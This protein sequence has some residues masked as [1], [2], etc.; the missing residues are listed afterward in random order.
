MKTPE[1]G[2]NFE[3]VYLQANSYWQRLKPFFPRADKLSMPQF[4]FFNDSGGQPPFLV[5][6]FGKKSLQPEILPEELTS[7]GLHS[8]AI[9]INHLHIIG[10]NLQEISRHQELDLALDLSEE[11]THAATCIDGG[12]IWMLPRGMETFD[13]FMP[14]FGLALSQI[15]ERLRLPFAVMDV[16]EF[17]PPLGQ[18]ALLGETYPEHWVWQ[19]AIIDMAALD[20]SSK[21]EVAPLLE[22]I[23]FHLPRLAGELLVKQ[24]NRD[25]QAIL[26]DNPSLLKLK[27]RELFDEYCIPLLINGRLK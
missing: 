21:P 22:K 1:V 20:F 8:A 15:I 25:V 6:N 19:T 5:D 12:E 10:I 16:N 13:G 9:Y 11:I 18:C 3:D 23:I 26:E 24:Y 14:G 7:R 27:G 17:F 2:L 4:I